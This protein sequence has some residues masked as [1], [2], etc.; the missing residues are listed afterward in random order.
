MGDFVRPDHP[1]WTG[2]L[3]QAT[4][5]ALVHIKGRS[6]SLFMQGSGTANHGAAGILTVMAEDRY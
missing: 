4:A 3:A 5:S 2:Q 6:I 1:K